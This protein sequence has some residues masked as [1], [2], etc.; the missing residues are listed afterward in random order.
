VPGGEN[1]QFII[2]RRI[3]GDVRDGGRHAKDFFKTRRLIL[4]GG[5]LI[6]AQAAHFC[7][8]EGKAFGN[9]LRLAQHGFVKPR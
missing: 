9:R 4:L 1:K 2:A 5:P 3:D 6:I 8:G 7:I